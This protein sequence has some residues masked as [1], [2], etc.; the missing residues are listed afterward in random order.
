VSDLYLIES[1][2]WQEF[3]NKKICYVMFSKSDCE[4][5]EF[6][7]KKL[8]S[9]DLNREFPCCK[10]NLD[11]PGFADLKQT[12][13]WISSIDV[14]PFSAIFSEGELVDSWSG[15]NIDML[16]SKLSAISV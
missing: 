16:Q 8:Q 5:C 12:Y 14:L 7:E 10:I 15:S 2:N 9:L 4:Q 3:L 6:L 13:S 1:S 11:K